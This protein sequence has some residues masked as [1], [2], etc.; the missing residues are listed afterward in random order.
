MTALIVISVILLAIFGLA[1]TR[2]RFRFAYGDGIAAVLRVW[3][4]KIRILPA[5]EPKPPDP[6]DYSIKKFRRRVKKRL[7]REEKKRARANNKKS[8]VTKE[9]QSD[10]K[11][12]ARD[13]MAL[14]KMLLDALKV[15]FARFPKYLRTDTARLI[16][17]VAG[18]D[19]AKTAV[20][21]GA[22]V[23]GVQ[24][25]ITMLEEYTDFRLDKRGYISVYPD[26]TTEKWTAEIDLEFSIRVWQVLATVLP[27]I[28]IYIHRD[29]YRS[30]KQGRDGSEAS[31]DDSAAGV[32][33]EA[34]K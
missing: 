22:T 13:P 18:D 2:I 9:E 1:M 21:Y 3:F 29:K 12:S 25:V 4:I 33:A 19:A 26:F 20:T 23:Q 16:I 32:E 11:S 17:G 10:K 27:L 6:K 30:K 31:G 8:S 28:P 7:K 24:Y 5:K 15:F 34:S 14:V